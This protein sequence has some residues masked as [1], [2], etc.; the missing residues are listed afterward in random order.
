MH[1]DVITLFPQ[2]FTV[3][4]ETSLL[5]KAVAAGLV[6]V[7]LHDPRGR[8]L[9]KHRA[10]DDEPYGGGAGMV[11]RPEPIFETVEPLIRPN[12][13][14]ILLSPRGKRLV[15]GS[16]ERLAALEHMVLI[17]GRYEGVDER[18][19]QHLAHEELSI[20]DFVLAGGEIAAM[21][22][23]EATSRLIPGVLGNVRSLDTESHTSGALEYPQYTRPADYRG[24]KV[25]PVLLSGNHAEVERWRQEESKHLTSHRRSELS[26]GSDPVDDE[27]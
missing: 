1:V 3:H 2:L 8:G 14:V 4:L 7:A 25:P 13:R 27:G 17:C 16:V 18:V 9:G 20:G 19:A 10:V 15:Q 5:G 26:R 22:V 21:A 24:M 12:T 23:I 6:S 11:M